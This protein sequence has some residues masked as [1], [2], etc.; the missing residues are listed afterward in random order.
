MRGPGKIL[1]IMGRTAEGWEVL[2]FVIVA[3][4]ALAL[5]GFAA[6]HLLVKFTL[7]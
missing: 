6:F 5:L 2:E 3:A 7:K 4:C 1:T